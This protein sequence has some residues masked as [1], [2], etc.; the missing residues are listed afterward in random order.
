MAN[1]R[2]GRPSLRM[3][4]RPTFWE[5][6]NI[7]ST[8]GTGTV[9]VISVISE[10]TLENTPNPTLVRVRGSFLSSVVSPGVS[11]RAHM[12]MGL[13]VV[14]ARAFAVPAVEFPLT[15]IGSDW[16]WWD[17]VSF[18][19]DGTGVT[20]LDEAGL[21]VFARTHVDNKAMRKI[22]LNQVVALVLQ[23]AALN[24]T[25]TIQVSGVLRILFKK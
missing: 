8:V 18:N 7:D 5:G 2:R 25:M 10:A 24:S 21:S 4:R 13:I 6:Q 15:D 9:Q 19:A 22:G 14:D 17:T 11:A 3:P 20:P 23:N 12:V 16:L 1:F